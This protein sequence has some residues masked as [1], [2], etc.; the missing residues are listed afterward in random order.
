MET[1]IL[2]VGDDD[3]IH[4]VY[5]HHFASAKDRLGEFFVLTAGTEIP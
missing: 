2:A 1:V 3:V 4:H 5:S